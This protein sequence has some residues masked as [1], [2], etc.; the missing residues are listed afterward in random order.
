[1]TRVPKMHKQKHKTTRLKLLKTLNFYIIFFPIWPYVLLLYIFFSRIC[2]F[3]CTSSRCL[4]PFLVVIYCVNLLPRLKEFMF[5]LLVMINIYIFHHIRFTFST[6]TLRDK[7]NLLQYFT[8][9]I[10]FF[11]SFS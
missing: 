8:S 1:M 6:Q 3:I 5:P 2:V 7:A 9:S 4:F 10:Y 11:L